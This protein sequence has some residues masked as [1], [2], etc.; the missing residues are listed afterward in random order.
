MSESRVQETS[1]THEQGRGDS[2]DLMSEARRY[3]RQALQAAPSP[4]ESLMY[5]GVIAAAGAALYWA[6]SRN[7]NWGQTQ[8]WARDAYDRWQ[9]DYDDDQ[10]R[11]RNYR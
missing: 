8:R 1:R 5:V 7:H 10:P 11:R 9:G 2:G 4:G 3:G 6:F